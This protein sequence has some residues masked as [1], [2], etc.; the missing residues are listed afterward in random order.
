MVPDRKRV[1]VG[2]IEIAYLHVGRAGAPRLVLLHGMAETSHSCW[3]QQLEVLQNRYDCYAVDL[4]GHGQTT[5]GDDEGTLE[6]LG[7]DLLGFLGAVTGSAVVVGFSMGAT[8][9]LWAAAQETALIEHVVAIGGSSVI[10][11]AT[12]QFFR[13]TAELVAR[14]DLLVLHEEMARDV[15]AMFVAN[16]GRAQAYGA[17]RIASVGEGD[18]YANAGL[19]MA[20]MRE[21]PLQKVLPRISCPVDVVGGEFDKW[22]PRKACDIILEGLVHEQVRFTEI[23]GVGHLMSVDEPKVVTACIDA[24]VSAPPVKPET[25]GVAAKVAR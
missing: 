6:Q 2:D 22:C 7:E 10:S 16:P 23:P 19:A 24:L 21:R 13:D 20:G 9:A 17:R 18:G 25:D 12:A 15:Q 5:L 14:R 4:R 1:Q 11:S 8:I 3:A